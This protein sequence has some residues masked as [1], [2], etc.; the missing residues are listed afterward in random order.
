MPKTSSLASFVL[1]LCV[2]GASAD[3]AS[4][5]LA[6]RRGGSGLSGSLSSN[7]TIRQ[8]QLICDPAAGVEAAAIDPN[9]S[10]LAQ[11]APRR[12]SDSVNYDPSVVSLTGIQLGTGYAGSGR[13][14]V[15]AGEGTFLQDLTAFLKKPAGTET[16]YVQL[17]FHHG[18]RGNL[19][20]DNLFGPA[21][22]PFKIAVPEGYTPNMSDG[23]EGFDTH[24]FFF[25]YKAGVPGTTI[26]A[27][28][29]FASTSGRASG[30]S[31][32]FLTG[33]DTTAGS[34]EFTIPASQITPAHVEGALVTVPLPPAVWAGSRSG[35]AKGR[36][37]KT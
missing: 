7:P 21:G 15:R 33:V 32:D 31:A 28:D 5:A 22:E 14:E 2:V 17:F 36:S 8:Q 10:A 18:A 13:V 35:P 27:Y 3:V 9:V 11:G 23:P 4:A 12:G 19:P 1:A 20:P 24:S 30:T 25:T 34:Q 37:C 29:I 16:G 26:A 6:K